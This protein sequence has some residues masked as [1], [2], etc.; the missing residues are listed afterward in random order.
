MTRHL[1]LPRGE[2]DFPHL[3]E[4]KRF[5][6]SRCLGPQET[7]VS[8]CCREGPLAC[9]VGF[10]VYGFGIRDWRSHWVERH[11]YSKRLL[12]SAS[13]PQ[14]S[15]RDLGFGGLGKARFDSCPGIHHIEYPQLRPKPLND[16]ASVAN[17]L[18]AETSRILREERH[19]IEAGRV[20]IEFR[21]RKSSLSFF[22]SLFQ[23]SLS[24]V[25]GVG[26]EDWRAR[27]SSLSFLHFP[28]SLE[29]LVAFA[30]TG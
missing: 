23:D 2:K 16:K 8:R 27:G 10:M 21:A 9:S 5:Y 19:P 25:Q 26:F 29:G 15:F 3:E 30:L 28:H 18:F 20:A 7:A 24:S 17:N 13:I 1:I 22:I 14:F 4:G 12:G 6:S 11:Q